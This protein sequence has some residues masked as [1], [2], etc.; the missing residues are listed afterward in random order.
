MKIVIAGGSGHLGRILTRALSVEHDVVV[1][2]R[3]ENHAG[4]LWD[5]RTLGPWSAELDGADVLINL[6]GRSVDCRYDAAHRAEILASRVEST[7]V[8]GEAIARAKRP[9]RVWLQSSTATIYAHRYDADNGEVTGRIGGN[10]PDTPE[11]WRFSIE[12]AEAWERACDEARTPR[13]R[14]VKLRTA[15][16]MSAEEGGAFRAMLRHVRLRFGRFGDGRQYMSWIHERDFVAAVRWLIADDEVGGVVNLAAPHPLPNGDFLRAI[17]KAWG[18]RL[19]IPT[20]GL[21]LRFGAWLLRTEP[22][23]VLKSR[24]VV[25]RRLAERGFRFAFTEWPDAARELCARVRAGAEGSTW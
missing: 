2:T 14:K 8:L 22:E 21:V 25:S 13:T 12:V 23:L 20:G 6:A 17:A 11:A 9:P 15:M 10:E 18:T 16:V 19:A 3:D 5:G 7:R 1:L 24:R 4:V